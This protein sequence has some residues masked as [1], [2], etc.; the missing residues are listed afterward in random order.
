MEGEDKTRRQPLLTCWE[1]YLQSC[2][3]VP[4]GAMHV[5]G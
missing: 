2:R 4:S 3:G 5:G 1:G